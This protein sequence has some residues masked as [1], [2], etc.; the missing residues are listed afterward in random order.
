MLS[1][2]IVNFEQLGPGLPWFVAKAQTGK[3][4]PS[5]EFLL[6]ANLSLLKLLFNCEYKLPLIF[7][8]TFKIRSDNKYQNK[9]LAVFSVQ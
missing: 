2:D 8:K 4:Q 6:L 9:S 7:C 5:A 1:N 3:I